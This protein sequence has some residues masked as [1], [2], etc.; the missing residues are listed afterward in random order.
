[1]P[2]HY[3]TATLLTALCLLPL[4]PQD[5]VKPPAEALTPGKMDTTLL[6]KMEWL[7]GTWVMAN[8]AKVTEEHW[9]PVQGT[10]I[11]GSSH[12]FDDTRSTF[13]EYLRIGLRNGTISYVAMPGGAP[14]TA[15]QLVKLE[16]GLMVF[17]N[18]KHDHPQRI[19]YEKTADGVTATIG[20]L[21]GTRS[22]SFVFKKKA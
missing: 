19:S 14:P 20:M 21:D 16:D 12:S 1:M 8:G 7:C 5:P 17:E 4:A 2:M 11:L 13:F 15:F 6:K 3:A 10:T 22:K 18:E 9:R